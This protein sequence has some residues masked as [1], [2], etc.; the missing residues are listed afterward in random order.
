M[1]LTALLIGLAAVHLWM[2][3]RAVDTGVISFGRIE[4]ARTDNP[5][6]FWTIMIGY[7]IFA[8]LCMLAAA[9]AAVGVIRI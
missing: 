2:I 7:A 4:A 6:G 5:K 1:L 3:Q 9:F 8:A